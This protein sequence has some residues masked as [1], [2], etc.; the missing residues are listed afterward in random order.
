M[1][2][3]KDTESQLLAVH[4]VLMASEV[5]C[6]MNF[7]VEL[8]FKTMFVDDQHNP[9]YVGV[10]R[11]NVEIHIQW[12]E[13]P[14]IGSGQDRP[15]Y[16]FVV[17]DVDALYREFS[18]RA[19]NVLAAAHATPWHAPANTPWGTREF[20]VRDPSGNGLQFY[21]SSSPTRSGDA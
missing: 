3:L 15:V 12:N 14:G 9:T 1:S 18:A 19:K 8:G 5:L 2:S 6:S 7:F 17:R 20:H 10:A 13:L 11:D 21:Q 4:P 16:R